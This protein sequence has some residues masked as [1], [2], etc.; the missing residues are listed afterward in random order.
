MIQHKNQSPRAGHRILSVS[1]VIL[2]ASALAYFG[3]TFAGGII[4]NQKEA[5][6]AAE[7]QTERE[8]F[9]KQLLER[10]GTLSVGD[11]LP[12]FEFDATDDHHFMLS[13]LI[14]GNT[15]ITYVEPTCNS[16]HGQ[17]LMIDSLIKSNQL[18]PERIIMIATGD[19]EAT[20]FIH[21]ESNFSFR[22][23]NDH[24]REIGQKYKISTYPFNIYIDSS[25]EITALHPY[26]LRRE[27]IISVR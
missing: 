12:D 27:E 3:G 4:N 16:C 22:I 15:I 23:L 2:L 5:E 10:M 17:L 8:L 20:K 1:L 14:V 24:Q 25:R 26:A 21:E 13:D 19:F 9:A 7:S 6:V 18:S 11:T